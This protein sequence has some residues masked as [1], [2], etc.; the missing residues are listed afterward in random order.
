[1]RL[2]IRKHQYDVIADYLRKVESA[3]TPEIALHTGFNRCSISVAIAKHPELFEMT[4]RKSRAPR[5]KLK[6]ELKEAA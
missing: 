5:W 4:G 3:T 2:A 1:M 6:D